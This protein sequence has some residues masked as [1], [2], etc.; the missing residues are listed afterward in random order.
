LYQNQLDPI[1]LA[2]CPHQYT[3]FE[4]ID[5]VTNKLPVVRDADNKYYLKPEVGGFMVGVFEGDPMLTYPD[6]VRERN[7]TGVTPSHVVNEIF[8]EDIEK[9]GAWFENCLEAVPVLQETGI[10]SWLHGPDS[11]SGDHAFNIGRL[12]HL[13]NSYVACGFNSQGIQTAAAVGLSLTEWMFDGYPHSLGVDFAACDIQR[14]NPRLGANIKH[15]EI[16]CSEGYGKVYGVHYPREVFE[17]SRGHRFSPLHDRLVS[18]G[19]VFGEG[20]GWE[21]ALYFLGDKKQ[22]PN[23]HFPSVWAE[24]HSVVNDEPTKKAE[25]LR[26]PMKYSFRAEDTEFFEVEKEECLAARKDAVVF[27]LSAFGKIMVSGEDAEAALQ[28][29]CSADVSKPPGNLTYSLILN[30]NGGIQGD[31]TVCRLADNQFYIVTVAFQ[32]DLITDH[33]DKVLGNKFKVKVNDV[34]ENLGVVALMGPKSRDILTSITDTP[35]LLFDDLQPP[36]T[37]FQVNVGGVPC[38]ALR[39]SFIGELGW[40][41]HIPRD[42][43]VEVYDKI[44][45][46]AQTVDI[47]CRDAGSWALVE[48]LRTEKMFVHYGHDITPA[49]N[50]LDSGLGFACKLKTDVDF[51]G[52]KSL[53]KIKARG[54][55]H[56]R[57]VSVT[58]PDHD[59]VSLW[60][61]HGNEILYRNGKKV[62]YMTS[63]CWF[64]KN[65][66]IR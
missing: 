38:L 55:P 33:L 17:S 1:V 60:G 58:M 18:K 59:G 44:F 19:A 62:G 56:S 4:A 54:S 35:E 43:T 61:G 6:A 27:D 37:C 24:R 52:R 7:A 34:T 15:C 48:S 57:M 29:A 47:P 5:G 3:C 31:L 30:D 28:Y 50:P 12:W 25:N 46:A 26:S 53:E 36:F 32:P 13:D 41:L 11:H 2:C 20:Y 22:T 23:D 9:A 51:V 16:R 10:K 49:E 14:Y 8:E 21:R 39:V 63:G 40:E 45:E 66:F 65:I 42:K 64:E